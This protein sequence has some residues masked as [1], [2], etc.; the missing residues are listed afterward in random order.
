MK[1]L[2]TKDKRNLRN[3]YKGERN[4]KGRRKIG[5]REKDRRVKNKKQNRWYRDEMGRDEA[6]RDESSGAESTR[7]ESSTAV[8]D[9][10]E[11]SRGETVYIV[12]YIVGSPHQVVLFPCRMTQ[13]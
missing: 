4:G 9:K 1:N 5:E 11:E 12:K 7:I 8:V 6:R 3:N 10:R 13:S 2:G